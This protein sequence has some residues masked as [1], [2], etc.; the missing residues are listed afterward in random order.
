MADK[1]TLKT[2]MRVLFTGDSI[3]DC[4]RGL[5]HRLGTGYVRNIARSLKKNYPELNISIEN[6]GIGGNTTRDLLRRWQEDCID[7][8]PDVLSILIGVNDLW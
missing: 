2:D 7:V 6:T 4:G 5:V 1:I 3:T 8:R